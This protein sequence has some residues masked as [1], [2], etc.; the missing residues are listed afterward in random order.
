MLQQSEPP[1]G[2]RTDLRSLPLVTIDGADARDFDDAVWAE[3]DPAPGNRPPSDS[4][5]V[6]PAR[7]TA[8]TAVTVAVGSSLFD[9]RFGLGD[10]RPRE[11]FEMPRFFNDVLVTPEASHGDVALTIAGPHQQAVIGALHQIVRATERR[12]QLR[13]TREGWNELL[14]RLRDDRQAGATED[15]P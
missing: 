1:L 6:D 13:W 4:G 7:S 14:Q 9:T 12:L 11:L 8:G 5:A 15:T 2:D 3:P 10:R